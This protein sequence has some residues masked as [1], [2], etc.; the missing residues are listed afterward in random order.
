MKKWTRNVLA[1][2]AI[3]AV[4]QLAGAAPTLISTMPGAGDSTGSV[5][6]WASGTWNDVAAGFEVGS[7]GYV[8]NLRAALWVKEVP[9]NRLGFIVGIASDALIGS[10]PDSYHADPPPGSLWE[11]DVCSS[12]QQMVGSRLQSACDVSTNHTTGG[13]VEL[14]AGEEFAATLNVFLP[15]AGTYWLYTRYVG[16]DSIN[17]WK[18]NTSLP[19]TDLFAVRTGALD[20][21]DHPAHRTFFQT[22]QPVA[23]LAL[24][25]TF[26]TVPEPSAAVLGLTGLAVLAGLRRRAGR[27]VG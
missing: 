25:I 8:T 13:R 5:D 11:I 4:P 19:P 9:N 26:E 10:A 3:V 12:V 6:T 20:D 16:E 21:V 18:T 23:P 22:T 1:G 14:A 17:V 15:G 24:A 7:A 2:L 27:E